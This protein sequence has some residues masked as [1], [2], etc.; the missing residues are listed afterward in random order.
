MVFLLGF[1]MGMAGLALLMAPRVP[2]RGQGTVPPATVRRVGTVLILFFPAL[3]SLR[4]LLSLFEA[5]WDFNVS[6]VNW[7]FTTLW[8]F[9]AFFLLLRG[10]PPTRRVVTRAPLLPPLNAELPLQAELPV[11]PEAPP[12]EVPSVPRSHLPAKKSKKMPEQENPFDFS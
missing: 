4:F 11:L 6:V 3:L 5:H 1:A 7:T 10:V 2:W 8:F 9:L 12:P